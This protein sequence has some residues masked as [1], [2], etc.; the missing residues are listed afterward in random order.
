MYRNIG[1]IEIAK[2]EMSGLTDKLVPRAWPSW[3]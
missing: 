3:L 1:D 2:M